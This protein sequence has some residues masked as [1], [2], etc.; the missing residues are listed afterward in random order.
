MAGDTGFKAHD[1]KVR[2]SIGGSLQ[3]QD[4]LSAFRHRVIHH[5]IEVLASRGITPRAIEVLAS[6]CITACARLA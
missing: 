5:V 1:D 4:E 3:V 6:R 2:G